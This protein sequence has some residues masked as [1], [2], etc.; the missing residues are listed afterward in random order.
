MIPSSED[1]YQLGY[2]SKLHGFKGELTVSVDSREI[3]SYEGLE[4]VFIEVKG[5]LIPYQVGTLEFK[6][7][8]TMKLKVDGIDREDDARKLIGAKV[9]IHRSDIAESDEMREMLMNLTGFMVI[10]S[11]HG[12]IGTITDVDDNPVNPLLKIESNGKEILLPLQDQFISA[13]DQENKI[14]AI[15][16]PE[17]LID[18]YLGL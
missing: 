7:N 17:G 12:E 8:S 9:F 15:S 18:F 16:A 2:I 3:N 1:L 6:T 4:H 11:R 10:D 14:I 13:I 5:I